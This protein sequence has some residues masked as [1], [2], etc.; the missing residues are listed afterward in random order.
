MCLYKDMYNCIRKK[1]AEYARNVCSD[2][3]TLI[4]CEEGT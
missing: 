3:D 1:L 4:G 2:Q